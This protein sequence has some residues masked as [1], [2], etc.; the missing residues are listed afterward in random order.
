M[1]IFSS[2]LMAARA[3]AF[4]SILFMTLQVGCNSL[5]R[6]PATPTKTIAHS[7]PGW[8]MYQKTTERYGIALPARWKQ[9]SMD[10]DKL[11]TSIR[12]VA[13]DPAT[14]ASLTEFARNRIDAGI[15]FLAIDSGGSA[16]IQLS[17]RHMAVAG[18]NIDSLAEVWSKNISAGGTQL[19]GPVSHNAVTLPMGEAQKITYV[20]SESSTTQYLVQ[21]ESDVYIVTLGTSPAQAAKYDS[22]F[23]RIGQSFQSLQ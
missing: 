2:K 3:I 14:A 22:V 5:N 15:N 16:V 12:E 21:R 17:W 19:L 1:D 9:I 13:P 7:E 6:A 10:P 11:E 20:T 4:G 23:S 18:V 8:M